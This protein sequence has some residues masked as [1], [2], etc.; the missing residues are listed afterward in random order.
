MH[1][2]FSKS[3]DPLNPYHKRILANFDRS[4]YNVTNRLTHC[5]TV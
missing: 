4:I 5:D 3:H 2:S 1:G